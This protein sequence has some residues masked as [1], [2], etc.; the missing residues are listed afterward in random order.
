M[1]T[2][3]DC[4]ETFD[5]SLTISNDL[6]ATLLIR[7]GNAICA[8]GLGWLGRSLRRP[9]AGDVRAAGASKTPP[10]PPGTTRGAQIIL[11]IRMRLHQGIG[12]SS[13]HFDAPREAH[14]LCEGTLMR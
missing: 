4:A 12:N 2:S 6:G 8:V 1:R 5:S 3:D 14:G 10:Q 9:G 11:R 7:P 13:L